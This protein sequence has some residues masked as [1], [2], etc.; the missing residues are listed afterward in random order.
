MPTEHLVEMVRTQL[1]QQ[2][3]LE[4]LEQQFQSLALHELM[5]PAEAVA[6]TTARAD[7]AE[8]TLEMVAAMESVAVRALPILDPAVAVAVLEMVQEALADQV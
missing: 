4:R 2:V 8:L 7:S 1:Q 6:V 5:D 3:A